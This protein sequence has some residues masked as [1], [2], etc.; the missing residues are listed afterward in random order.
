MLEAWVLIEEAAAKSGFVQG[1]S[2]PKVNAPLFVEELIRIGKL[3]SSNALLLKQLRVLRNQAV[4]LSDF[5]LTQ[6][7]ADRYLQLA[8]S[9]SENILSAE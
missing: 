2:I 8:A 9:L 4:H 6:D 3:P 1:A 7:E 5:S